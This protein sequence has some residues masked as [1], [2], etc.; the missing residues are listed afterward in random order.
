MPLY[1]P[2]SF[3]RMWDQPFLKIRQNKVFRI[4]PT[5][6][7]STRTSPLRLFQILNH[8]HVCGINGTVTAYLGD[9]NESFPR[10]WDQPRFPVF[11]KCAFRIIPTYVGSTNYYTDNTRLP[12][13]HSHV[14]GINF[15][16]VAPSGMSA[17]SFPRMWDQ[18]CF[19]LK[20]KGF[21]RI[22]PTYVGS[23]RL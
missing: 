13:N 19:T 17:E 18:L 1:C 14:C 23:T 21:S 5:Y 11:L 12:S 8:S 3:P 4:I 15:S 6:V 9:A 10:M 16:T 2:E 7:G 22:I 20:C